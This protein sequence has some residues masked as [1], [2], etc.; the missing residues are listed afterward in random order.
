MKDLH[1][2]A[3]V[4][5]AARASGLKFTGCTDAEVA[6][7]VRGV[8][9]LLNAIGHL[10]DEREPT[11]QRDCHC[12]CDL[13]S[14]A[15]MFCHGESAVDVLLTGYV[16]LIPMCEACAEWWRA[17]RPKRVVWMSSHV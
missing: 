1:N 9:M 14:K 17:E 11:P 6:N 4:A 2:D 7:S 12:L 5:A 15:G 10:I 16:N 8:L 13:H 3:E